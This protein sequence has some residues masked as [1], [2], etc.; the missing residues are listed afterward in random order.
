MRKKV[1]PR[2][3]YDLP[4]TR[5]Q[6]QGGLG[7][8]FLTI[9]RYTFLGIYPAGMLVTRSIVALAEML[10]ATVAGAWG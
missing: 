4:F 10:L 5:T 2:S 7:G 1:D 6:M 3:P 8:C 9:V